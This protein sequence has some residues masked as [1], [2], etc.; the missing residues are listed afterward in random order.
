MNN[1]EIK[2]VT[3]VINSDQARKK[4]DDINAQL[5]TAKRKRQ[6]AFD[7][8]D[9]TALQTY[10][11]EVR[12]LEHQ[13]QRLQARAAT[14]EKTL[15]SLDNAT[16][17]ELKSTIKELTKELN[18]GKIERGSEEWKTLAAAISQANSELKKIK[19]EQKAATDLGEEAAD[20]GSK[21]VGLSTII[22]NV[23]GQFSSAMDSMMEYV[24]EYAEMQEHMSG[25]A[26]YTGLSAEEVDDLNESFKAMDTRT[27]RAQLNDLAGDAG[28]LGIT[29]KDQILEFVEAADQINV[30]LGEDLGE[31]AVKNIGKLAQLFG[32]A[33]S[34]GLKQAMLST[35]S[36][37]NEL[38]QSSSASEAYLM[39]FT[40]RLAG[41]GNQAGM[42]QAQVMAFGSILDQSMV[43]V[44]K[45]ATALQNTI[46]ALYRNPAQM[47]KVAG[48]NVQEFTNLLKTDGNAAI[49]QFIQALH[50]TGSLDKLA[51]AL[52]EMQLS[53]SGVTQTLSAL[54]QNIDSL[55]S[56]QEQATAA[57]QQGTSVTNEFNTANNTVQGRLEKAQQ[58]LQ[59]IRVEL[60]GQL[61]PV[62]SRGL[63]LTALVS[64]Y[65]AKIIPFI[66][67]HAKQ[68]AA[69][70]AVIVTYTTVA[71]LGLLKTKLLTAA[72][73]AWNA[74]VVAGRS[75][76]ATA[77]AA[78]LLLSTAYY[79]MTGNAV[80]LRAAQIALNNS[81][82]ANPYAAVLAAVVAIGSAIYLWCTRTKELSAA[83]RQQKE[84]QEAIRNVQ[85]TAAESTANEITRLQNL[86]NIILDNSK[87]V[88][89]RRA[90]I[91][92]LQS[93]IPAY[94]GSI[95][96]TGQLYNN[97]IGV[98][99]NYIAKLKQLAIAQ[100]IQDKMADLAAKKLDADLKLKDAK[101]NLTRVQKNQSDYLKRQ[102]AYNNN[103]FANMNTRSL[104]AVGVNAINA[105]DVIDAQ[106][107]VNA[108]QTA[109][110]AIKA[111]TTALT[112]YAETLGSVFDSA[113]IAGNAASSTGGAGYAPTATTG[114]STG[115]S[116]G[117]SG[118]D[119]HL[120]RIRAKIEELNKQ[121]RE[122]K[123]QEALR[124]VTGETTYLQYKRRLIE[125]DN[126]YLQQKRA[127]YKQGD[128]QIATIDKELEDNRK[129]LEE[130]NRDWSLEQIDIETNEALRALEE[131]HMR[132]RT[133][134]EQFEREKEALEEK[135]LQRRVEYLRNPINGADPEALH[136]E[137]LALEEKQNENLLAEKKRLYEKEKQFREDYLASSLD[138]Q[139]QTELTFAEKLY[140][141]KLLSE[142]EYE[143]AK[144]AIRQKF[145]DKRAAN[146]DTT[147]KNSDTTEKS[148]LGTSTDSLSTSVA[149]FG[150]TFAQLREKIDDGKAQWE[151]Y[152]AVGV[153]AL[154]SVSA[155]MS[156]VSSLMQENLNAEVAEVTA[157]YD[158]EI[159]AAGETTTK[160]KA[161]EE[162]KQ[163]EI[164]KIKNKYNKKMMTIELAQAVAQT[165]MN[166]VMAY[167]SVVRTP[168]VG[169][170]LAPIAAAAALA[171]GAIQIASIK[172]QHAAEAAGYY[173]GG[174]TGGNSYRTEA[175][176]VHEGE[177]V[178]NHQAVNNP[179]VLP[180]LRLIDQAQ[181]TNRI[182]SLT[183]ADVSR[184]I[185]APMTTATNTS[186]GTT[187]VKVVDNTSTRT[188]EA[189]DRLSAQLDAGLAAYV[190]IDGPD[191]FARQWKRYNT[192]NAK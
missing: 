190:T 107:A 31:D 131:R 40:A 84:A 112:N 132:E 185:A 147:K 117:T 178:A 121:Q 35:G 134:D 175:G 158:A 57:F 123:T 17:K 71:N 130:T 61:L 135:R 36:I 144:E 146:G 119:N 102:E 189:L 69:L 159:E 26:K 143:K 125:I 49:L 86:T 181:R 183:A 4:L 47:A 38:A 137:E 184:A 20:F 169:P 64:S 2:T 74:V 52:K 162:E 157:R 122:E 113:V 100:A 79:K 37:I 19:D 141:E 115:G 139:E 136:D 182:A 25:V 188:T 172:Q 101:N 171:A 39:E 95:T 142:E 124:Q 150:N 59:E 68:V 99:N 187:T 92:A 50:D 165:A 45:S 106:D 192:M 179:N 29:S 51:P 7:K 103:P 160:G 30:A 156:S 94:H 62:V 145:Q 128:S 9:A 8:G 153:A 77:Q 93:I 116:G 155:M 67:S 191:G 42:T 163:A 85:V 10:T 177:F 22:E 89:T 54:A 98:V 55:R 78:G 32:D 73:A 129:K 126:K 110:N 138:E 152:A 48:L 87:S 24:D 28:R 75:V 16:P 90:A 81:L 60:G 151:D 88:D 18:S 14:V 109:V 97:N 34:M 118:G 56:T 82:K 120:D 5:E 164:A 41:V 105:K 96:K 176:V 44:E 46:T 149:S 27:A 154:Q 173:E 127:L 170:V 33:D 108:A 186:A 15:R 168:F 63:D 12:N 111:Q 161:L 91:T 83:Q 53:G 133:S 43:G 140:N 166:A 148:L 66:A 167:G 58:K 1:Q 70:S 114:K 72:H 13:S 23:S 76:M 180:V 80:K 3:L 21:W 104:G 65:I 174:F 6:E 11:K